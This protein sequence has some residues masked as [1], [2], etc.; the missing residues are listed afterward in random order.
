MSDSKEPCGCDESKRLRNEL[1]DGIA[2]AFN[3]MEPRTQDDLKETLDEQ[4]Q[5]LETNYK[6]TKS[7]LKH[8][9]RPFDNGTEVTVPAALRYLARHRRP[10]GG[11][12]SFNAEHLDQLAE[13]AERVFVAYRA[14]KEELKHG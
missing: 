8:V 14:M 10:E 2:F 4:L 11:E 5:V 6:A 3:M 7:T 13:E 12:E 9:L 1:V